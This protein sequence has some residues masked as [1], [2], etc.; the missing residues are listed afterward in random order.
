MAVKLEKLQNID[1]QAP[2]LI[3]GTPLGSE[4]ENF[5]ASH[6]IEKMI[7]EDH[8][9]GLILVNHNYPILIITNLL[10]TILSQF[11]LPMESHL[12]KIVI[13]N[14]T[15]F[16]C[17]Y[18][19]NNLKL[20]TPIDFTYIH[21]F[22]NDLGVAKNLDKITKISKQ[23]WISTLDYDGSI[24]YDESFDE[25]YKLVIHSESS[26]LAITRLSPTAHPIL[27]RQTR[28]NFRT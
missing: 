6:V 13:G 3:L 12:N 22:D 1:T 20:D 23:L 11:G 14:N 16:F 15:L 24:F 5:V 2:F 28:G 9:N 17:D 27:E 7:W 10:K 4:V 26:D 21:H 25:K 8:Y 19:K 18:T